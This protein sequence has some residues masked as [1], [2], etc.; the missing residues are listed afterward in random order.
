MEEIKSSQ[1]TLRKSLA[2]FS[3]LSHDKQ[4]WMKFFK[5]KQCKSIINEDRQC[6]ARQTNTRV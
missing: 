3:L 5:A 1:N 2:D 4:R 6:I